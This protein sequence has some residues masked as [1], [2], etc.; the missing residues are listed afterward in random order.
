VLFSFYKSSYTKRAKAIKAYTS[1]T[2]FPSLSFSTTFLEDRNLLY[3]T[4]SNVLYP[5]MREYRY[6]DYIYAK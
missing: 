5:Q 3:D 2:K 1:L 4:G 6:M